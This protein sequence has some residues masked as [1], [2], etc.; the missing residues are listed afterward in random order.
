MKKFK[1]FFE[2]KI[3]LSAVM[4]VLLAVVLVT[5]TYG[6]YALNNTDRL[7]GLDLNVGGTGGLKVAIKPNGADI[8]VDENVRRVVKDDKLVAIIPI[9]LREFTSIEGGKIAPGAYGELPFWIT[10]LSESIRS[11]K[12]KV[13]MVYN[14]GSGETPYEKEWPDDLLERFLDLLTNEEKEAILNGLTEEDEIA[15]FAGYTE[16]EKEEILN[17]LTEDVKDRLRAELAGHD[18]EDGLTDEEKK[19]IAEIET[20]IM[21]HFTVYKTIYRDEEGIVRFKDP[22]GFYINESDNVVAAKGS[23]DYMVEKKDQIY[24]VWNYEL[25]DIPEFWEL[26][27]FSDYKFIDAVDATDGSVILNEAEVRAGVRKYDEED[28]KLGNYLDHVWFMVYIEGSPER[29]NEGEVDDEVE[30]YSETG[31]NV[32][33]GEYPDAD[34]VG[35]D[36]AAEGIEEG[37]DVEGI[38]EG[39]DADE[40]EGN[41]ESEESDE[42]SN[43]ESNVEDPDA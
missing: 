39:S 43:E 37:S 31:L 17:G 6:W 3:I 26:E 15:I 33:T 11:Y 23:L 29:Y 38:E 34:G 24:W 32:E 42:G 40:I 10:S 35:D 1:Q 30:S 7:Y 13:K 14:P 28:T 21:D 19:K 27:R 41:P 18:V 2:E 8:M 4:C 20:M 12:I 36:S 22:L 5:A 16:E 9:N 25:T